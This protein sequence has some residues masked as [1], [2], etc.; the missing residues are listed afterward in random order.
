MAVKW[1]V[2]PIAKAAVAGVTIT[3]NIPNV[4][5]IGASPDSGARTIAIVGFAPECTLTVREPLCV[6]MP[7]AS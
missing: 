2:S 6:W 4:T 3:A 1:S 7:P 5:W